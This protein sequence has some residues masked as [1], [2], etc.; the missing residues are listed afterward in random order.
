[1][2][3]T[4][5]TGA[6]AAQ[7]DVESEFRVQNDGIARIT[8]PTLAT[9]KDN[10]GNTWGFILSS[11]AGGKTAMASTRFQL[12]KVYDSAPDTWNKVAAAKKVVK[13]TTTV[14]TFEGG[15]DT[16][17][18]SG[19]SDPFYTATGEYNLNYTYLSMVT[20]VSCE[21]QFSVTFNGK[22]SN[23]KNVTYN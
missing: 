18:C 4:L 22:T 8:E 14:A 5:V 16:K 10:N 7:G 3:L 13:N 2:S 23:Y 20:M 19:T 9:Y 21:H 11:F 12:E 15:Y 17:Y 1:M 6:F